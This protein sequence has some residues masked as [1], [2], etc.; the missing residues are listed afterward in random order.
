MA[1]RGEKYRFWCPVVVL[2]LCL[3][4][5][6]ARLVM[7]HLGYVEIEKKPTYTLVRNTVALRGSIFSSTGV[8]YARSKVVWEYAVD[9]KAGNENAVHPNRPV[10]PA[11]R[12]ANI[13][14]LSESL[15]L[16]VA[17]VMDAYAE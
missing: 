6:S 12:W 13:T 11:V 1:W 10:D 7:L 9:P 2:G 5:L 14:N 4:G 16:P 17:K 3:A 8:P 15:N